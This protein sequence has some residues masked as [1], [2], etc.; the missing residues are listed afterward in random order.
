MGHVV[1]VKTNLNSSQRVSVK[2]D[3]Q[4]EAHVH[5][6]SGGNHPSYIDDTTGTWFIYDQ[7]S[8][9]YYDTGIHGD[10]STL[11]LSGV[12]EEFIIDGDRVLFIQNV[13]SSKLTGIEALA[14]E[15]H[16]IIGD[17][18]I[19]TTE[20]PGIVKANNAENGVLVMQDGTMIISDVNVNK[21]VQTNG[22]R[23]TLNGGNSSD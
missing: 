11:S 3:N 1:H 22:E 5:T 7:N 17:V 13:D 15:I 4:S 10:G 23:F 14:E 21:L 19:A 9:K 2:T 6:G 12:S 20:I 8:G 16:E 18:P